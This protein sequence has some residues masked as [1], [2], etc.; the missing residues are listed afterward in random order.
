MRME[1]AWTELLLMEQQEVCV[2]LMQKFEQ[3]IIE[4][5]Y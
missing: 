4:A 1:G 2:K 3:T 5:V